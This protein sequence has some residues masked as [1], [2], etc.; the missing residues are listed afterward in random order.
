MRSARRHRRRGCAALLLVGAL[1]LPTLGCGTG[2]AAAPAVASHKTAL[3]SGPGTPI[4]D[5]FVVAPDSKLVGVAFP[6]DPDGWVAVLA[7]DAN[8]LRVVDA[9]LAQAAAHGL[10]ASPQCTVDYPK[11]PTYR[12]ELLD[13]QHKPRPGAQSIS[14]TTGTDNGSGGPWWYLFLHWGT[15]YDRTVSFT[16]AYMEYAPAGKSAPV[17]A[18]RAPSQMPTMTSWKRPTTATVGQRFDGDYAGLNIGHRPGL[19]VAPGSELAAPVADTDCGTGGLAAVLKT[20]GSAEVVRSYVQQFMDNDF[21]PG[22]PRQIRHSGATVMAGRVAGG[23]DL[24][25]TQFTSHGTHWLLI[26]RCND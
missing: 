25:L 23:G 22:P 20:S 18:S 26:L 2:T 21:P 5:G 11:G 8:P 17:A 24:S 7:V 14:C 10:H 13:D 6:R 19:F 3:E 1:V 4:A 9:Y 15:L 12:Q 16:S